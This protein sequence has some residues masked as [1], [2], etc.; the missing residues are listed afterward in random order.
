MAART[1][2]ILVG[3]CSRWPEGEAQ[4]PHLLTLLTGLG[5]RAD[6][7]VPAGASDFRGQSEHVAGGVYWPPSST[8]RCLAWRA[9]PPSDRGYPLWTSGFIGDSDRGARWMAPVV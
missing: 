8:G 5:R 7:L 1:G 6:A 2:G 4:M 9:S 3:A